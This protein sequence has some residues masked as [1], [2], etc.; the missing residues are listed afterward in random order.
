MV[1]GVVASLRLARPE[2]KKLLAGVVMLIATALHAGFYVA[3]DYGLYWILNMV[4][5][6]GE[7]K[8]HPPGTLPSFPSKY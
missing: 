3:C 8:L 2:R 4:R 5:V 6:H 1:F 7:L